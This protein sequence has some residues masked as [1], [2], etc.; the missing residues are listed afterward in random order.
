[1]KAIAGFNSASLTAISKAM[2]DTVDGL[3]GAEIAQILAECGVPDTD[4]QSTK[5][6]RLYNALAL[7]QNTKNSGNHVV[8]FI[9]KAVNP[10]R[11][12]TNPERYAFFVDQL[13]PILALSALTINAEGKVAV[14]NKATSLDDALGRAKNLR[15]E[16]ER[17]GAHASVFEAC[18]A[19]LV[20]DNYFHAVLEAI[21]GIFERMRELSGLGTDGAELANEMFT[22]GKSGDPMFAINSL[23]NDSEKSEQRGFVNLLIGIF[24]M[25]RN[26]A[27]HAMRIYWPMT[28]EDAVDILC[29]ISLVH[30]K[31]DQAKRWRP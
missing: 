30:R 6:K 7:Q 25:F 12:T 27:A 17:R 1:M 23:S 13:V 24:G 28:R 4:P 18:Q 21:K 29:T 14:A 8:A 16:M 11:H 3:T 19:E 26:P 9:N 10:A 22:L 2:G 31:L 5:W 15:S 20:V